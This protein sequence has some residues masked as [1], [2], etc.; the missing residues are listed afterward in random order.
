VISQ[1]R[2]HYPD[3]PLSSGQAGHVHGGD[4]LPWAGAGGNDNFAPLRS[5][6]WQLHIYGSL[7]EELSSAA[8]ELGLAIYTFHWT[9]QAHEA[10][11]Q[12]DSAYLL[13]PDGYI[14]AALENKSVSMLKAPIERFGIRFKQKL[15]L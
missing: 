6:D 3:S 13:R 1:A 15:A 7:S 9:N 5:L 10:G 12:K 4:R 8:R 11:F 2:I 14:A